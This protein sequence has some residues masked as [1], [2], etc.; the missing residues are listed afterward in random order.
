MMKI[1]ITGI[2]GMLG[3]NIC[4]TLKDR[5]DITGIDLIDV[6][7]PGLSY[8]KLSLFDMETI[9]KNIAEIRPDILIH[10]AALVS[11]D[12]CEEEPEYARRLNT[13]V[14]A[15][16]AEV[17]DRHGIKMV[18]ISTDAV[19]DG[20]DSRL[21]TEE[22]TASP[23]NVYGKTKLDGEAAVLQFPEHLVL[24]TNIYGI[25]IQEKQSFGEWI[26]YALKD[27]K[28]LNMFTDIDFSPILV[29]ELAELIYEMC[30]KNLCGLYHA[31]GTGCITKYDFGVKLK[32]VFKLKSGEIIPTKCETAHLKA[33]RSKHMGMSN[34][35]LADALQIQIRTPEESIEAFYSLMEGNRSNGD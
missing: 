1:Y 24:R 16:L 17:C 13:D 8:P 23:I 34:Q 15:Q 30:R 11:V 10:T 14:T 4:N 2:A 3:Y 26:Y 32:E 19:F 22:D 12:E 6:E 33:K 27:G 28:T 18:Y 9:E 20:N 7:I 25:N 21:Y 5:A 31:C 29:N 35:K